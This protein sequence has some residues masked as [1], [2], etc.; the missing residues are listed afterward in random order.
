MMKSPSRGRNR[1]ASQ[2]AG[3]SHAVETSRASGVSKRNYNDTTSAN[4]WSTFIPAVGT[5][6]PYP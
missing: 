5:T 1:D 2:P 3:A 6:I 4:C